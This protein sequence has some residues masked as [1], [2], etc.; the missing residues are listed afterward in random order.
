[1][2]YEDGSYE[3][4]TVRPEPLPAVTM[5]AKCSTPDC[6]WQMR[7]VLSIEE[8]GRCCTCPDCGGTANIRLADPPKAGLQTAA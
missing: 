8:E 5:I 2:R 3:I 4:T 1:M 7:A 6:E